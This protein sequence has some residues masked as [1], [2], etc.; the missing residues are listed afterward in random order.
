MCDVQFRS[1]YTWQQNTAVMCLKFRFQMFWWWFEVKTCATL[2]V[3][4]TAC[5]DRTQKVTH[6]NNKENLLC[7]KLLNSPSG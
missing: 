6:H 3:I 5:S 7:H 2:Y 4:F 1:F